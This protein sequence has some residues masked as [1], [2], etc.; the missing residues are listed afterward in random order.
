MKC[1]DYKTYS[2]LCLKCDFPK[3]IECSKEINLDEPLKYIQV[4]RN[5]HYQ[6]S[7]NEC[8]TCGN[9][10]GYNPLDTNFRCS[11]CSQKISWK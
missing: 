1:R 11:K 6:F 2:V 10:I 4:K 8:P 7:W 5:D 9:S 3:N